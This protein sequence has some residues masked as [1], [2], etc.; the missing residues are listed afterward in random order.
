MGDK[1]EVILYQN[2]DGQ[3]ALETDRF[4]RLNM[5]SFNCQLCSGGCLWN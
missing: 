3:I 1:G 5:I 2:Q 4:L